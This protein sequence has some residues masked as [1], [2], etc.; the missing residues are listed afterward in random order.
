MENAEK[1]NPS[2]EGLPGNGKRLAVLVI[3]SVGKVRSFKIFPPLVYTAIVFLAIYIPVTIYVT[4]KFFS[5]RYSNEVLT[6]EIERLEKELVRD[7]RTLQ[8]T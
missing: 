6:K 1:I 8:K 5:L 3:G 7:K 4:N 2:P